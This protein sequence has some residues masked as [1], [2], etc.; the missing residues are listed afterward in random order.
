MNEDTVRWYSFNLK[1][2]KLKGNLMNTM[3]KRSQKYAS[4]CTP[5]KNKC[6]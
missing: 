3:V 5:L 2:K 6:R 1:K 4:L